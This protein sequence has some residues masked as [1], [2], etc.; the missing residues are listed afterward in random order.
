MWNTHFYTFMPWQLHVFSHLQS[1]WQVDPLI[2]LA[3]EEGLVAVCVGIKDRRPVRM[4]DADLIDWGETLHHTLI[5]TL[6]YTIIRGT[7]SIESNNV[8]SG[9][10]T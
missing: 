5:H 8:P 6:I 9:K 1:L 4:G 2:S 7:G 10:D 3:Q